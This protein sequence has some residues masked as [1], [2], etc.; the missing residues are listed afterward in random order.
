MVSLEP[1]IGSI[2]NRKLKKKKRFYAKQWHT[3]RSICITTDRYEFTWIDWLN[4]KCNEK[5]SVARASI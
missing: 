2:Q 1:N 5:T 3:N 4:C